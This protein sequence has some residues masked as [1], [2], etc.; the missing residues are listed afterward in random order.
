MD[1]DDLDALAAEYVLGTLAADERNHAETLINVDPGFGEI[2]RQW[3]RRLG[4]LNVMVEAVDPPAE[5]WD[6][7]KSGVSALPPAG[8]VSLAPLDAPAGTAANA[9]P[10]SDSAL[11]SEPATAVKGSE[12]VGAAGVIGLSPEAPAVTAAQAKPELAPSPAEFP[13][14]PVRLA[15]AKTE[16][17]LDA[18][19]LARSLTRWRV[20]SALACV[21]AVLLAAFIVLS[22]VDPA[23]IPSGGFHVPQLIAQQAAPV[24]PAAAAPA[25]RLVAVLQQ[26]PSPPAFL[27]TV[28][29][30]SR[31]LT[32]RTISAQAQTGHSYELW[33]IA[34]RSAPRA[35]GLVGGQ[36]FTQTPLPA[37][38]DLGTM[39]AA[40]YIISFEPA[41]GSK[42]AAPSGPI[43]FT[44]KLVESTPSATPRPKT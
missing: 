5:V 38:F 29:P 18:S 40:T 37:N 12:S 43:L 33:M 35:L 24:Q 10:G 32:V 25:R 21:V 15:P 41:G 44:G 39:Q 34:P 19:L 14:A 36:Q 22:Q 31:T 1:N 9:V 6:K 26:G 30:A 2:V 16:R 20:V 23:L 27:L 4:E 17:Q 28:D 11:E 42:A 7:I 3:E 8:G 13:L